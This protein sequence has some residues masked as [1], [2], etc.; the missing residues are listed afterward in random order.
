MT[1]TS[2]KVTKRVSPVEEPPNISSVGSRIDAPQ[3]AG[4]VQFSISRCGSVDKQARN[5]RI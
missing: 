5:V 2:Q 3:G 4:V 1:P